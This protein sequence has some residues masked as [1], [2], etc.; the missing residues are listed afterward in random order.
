M[1]LEIIKTGNVYQIWDT[2]E[3]NWQECNSVGSQHLHEYLA[4]RELLT[5]LFTRNQ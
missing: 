2:S 5:I 4:I 3:K 1:K